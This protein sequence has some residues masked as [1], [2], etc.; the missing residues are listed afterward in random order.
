MDRLHD[1]E[2]KRKRDDH[3]HKMIVDIGQEYITHRDLHR[4]Y[5]K[6][7]FLKTVAASMAR[8]KE[9]RMQKE[10]APQGSE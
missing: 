8:R 9:R 3:I 5:R 4:D 2:S 1:E 6:Q 7:K 10:Q